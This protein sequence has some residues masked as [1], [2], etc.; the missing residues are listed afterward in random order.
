MAYFEAPP[1]STVTRLSISDWTF[2]ARSSSAA[3]VRG[4]FFHRLP[5]R[6]HLL[7]AV[8]GEMFN[9]REQHHG[10]RILDHQRVAIHAGRA[11]VANH[12]GHAGVAAVVHRGI[13]NALEDQPLL[14]EVLVD[15]A[16]RAASAPAEEPAGAPPLAARRSSP[17]PPSLHPPALRPPTFAC[18]IRT[19][20][21]CPFGA[22]SHCTTTL[23]GRD[24]KV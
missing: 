7:L 22:V 6:F 16:L 3:I 8:V 24:A 20:T 13:Q 9:A 10:R 12:A 23:S 14:V 5:Q 15:I 19:F 18:A 1:K 21:D 17:P 11:A 2:R 4:E